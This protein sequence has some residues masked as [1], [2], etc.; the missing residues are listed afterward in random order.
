VH[1]SGPDCPAAAKARCRNA[2]YPTPDFHAAADWRHCFVALS[3][4]TCT[5]E[6]VHPM[7]FLNISA[8]ITNRQGFAALAALALLCCAIVIALAFQHVGGYVP[9]ALCLE[10]RTP[11][12]AA[13]PVLAAGLLLHAKSSPA[14]LIRLAFALAAAIM[15]YGMSLGVFHA[16]FEWGF[17]PGPQDCAVTS[18]GAAVSAGDLLATIDSVKAPSCDQAALRVLGLSFAGWNAVAAAMASGLAAIA[19]FTRD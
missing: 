8:P 18:G 16:G 4:L 2:P 11:Y 6:T 9:C 15:L 12:Y 5:D 7:A 17:W 3:V 19:A 1:D 14:W 13:M 10:Q